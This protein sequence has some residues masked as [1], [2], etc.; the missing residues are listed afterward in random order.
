MSTREIKSEIHNLL[1]KIPETVLE[2]ILNYL[3]EVEAKSEDQ[4]KASR[5]LSRILREEKEL[6]ETLA[7]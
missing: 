6:L 1:D 2:D 4:V 5:N 3:K 7:Q